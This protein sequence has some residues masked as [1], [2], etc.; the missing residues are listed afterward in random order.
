MINNIL[1]EPIINKYK[2]G[3]KFK[4]LISPRMQKKYRFKTE[5]NL[6]IKKEKS[7]LFI[8]K[9]KKIIQEFLE[10]HEN[11]SIASGSKDIIFKNGVCKRK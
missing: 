1:S 11:S 6:K 4:S 7:R 9:T 5:I 3:Y 8:D 2:L 10:R